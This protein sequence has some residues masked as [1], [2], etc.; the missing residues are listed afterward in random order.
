MLKMCSFLI[1]KTSLY[2]V[3]SLWTGTDADLKHIN[4]FNK[5]SAED[6]FILSQPATKEEI[7]NPIE[8]ASPREAPCGGD[9][10]GDGFNA[11]MANHW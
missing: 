5:L 1:S 8:V 11:Q 6:V 9:G 3:W 2:Q 10:R 7:E 4:P